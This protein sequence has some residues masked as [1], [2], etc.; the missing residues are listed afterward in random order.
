MLNFACCL[1]S[2]TVKIKIYLPAMDVIW[3][4]IVYFYIVRMY[5]SILVPTPIE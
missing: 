3:L 5:T 2:P 4:S 1:V